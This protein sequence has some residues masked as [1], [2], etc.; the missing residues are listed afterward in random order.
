[1][2]IDTTGGIRTIP[3][4]VTTLGFQGCGAS[5]TYIF[6]VCLP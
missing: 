6:S 3:P 2:N 5:T 1:L 4:V